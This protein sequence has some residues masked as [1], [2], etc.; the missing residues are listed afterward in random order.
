MN[1]TCFLILIRFLL[2]CAVIKFDCY[3]NY[4]MELWECSIVYSS[5]AH[6][7]SQI[8]LENFLFSKV[9]THVVMYRQKPA[10]ISY[11]I[12][13]VPAHAP[14]MTNLGCSF[15]IWIYQQTLEYLRCDYIAIICVLTWRWVT[16]PEILLFALAAGYVI[17]YIVLLLFF[18][19]SSLRQDSCVC[20]S[21]YDVIVNCLRLTPP[22]ILA[23]K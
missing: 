11:Q 21:F 2:L 7:S 1:R 19:F 14:G 10:H 20:V 13:G 5:N 22:H 9:S 16:T 6:S 18:V 12:C 23:C 4:N 8:C 3:I 17:W 15:Y